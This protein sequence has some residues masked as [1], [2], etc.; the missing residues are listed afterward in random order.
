MLNGTLINRQRLVLGLTRHELAKASGVSWQALEKLERSNSA[1]ATVLLSTLRRVAHALG[2]KPT[3]LLTDDTPA[4]SAPPDATVIGTVLATHT[5]GFTDDVLARALGWPTERVR[6]AIT[7]L[8]EQLQPV[9]Q[10]VRRVDGHSQLAP[11]KSTLHARQ[12]QALARRS[13]PL[14]ADHART[15]LR[16]LRRHN[17]N[18]YW[19]DFTADDRRHLMHLL[20]QGVLEDEGATVHPSVQTREALTQG[21]RRGHEHFPRDSRFHNDTNTYT[22]ALQ[23]ARHQPSRHSD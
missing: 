3:D 14:D 11:A 10:T 6:D 9:G 4:G 5:Q 17:R 16:V 2:L 13:N 7:T 21:P 23:H 19:E 18:R 1:D 15:L 8:T 20:A 12:A 22:A